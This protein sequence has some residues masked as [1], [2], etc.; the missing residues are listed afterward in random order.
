MQTIYL[1]KTIE[2]TLGP[3]WVAV[4]DDGLIAVDWQ[5][6]QANLV[7]R[8]RRRTGAVTLRDDA[9][10]TAEAA[11]Q[12]AEYLS[13]QRR[14]FTLPVDWSQMSD[15]QRLALQA[16]CA[17]PYGQTRTYRDIA[18]QIGHPLAVRA[19]GRA[20]AANPMPLV[21]PC[22]RL[23]GVDGSLRGYGGPGGVELK[24]WLL[25]MEQTSLV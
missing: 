9:A 19:V 22:H 16:V 11:R 18:A 5:I 3:V 7:E 8:I 12:V 21:I 1:G 20:N 23:I 10:R 25:K 6:P 14:E 24:A 17:V 2:T 15:F 4:S 13:G